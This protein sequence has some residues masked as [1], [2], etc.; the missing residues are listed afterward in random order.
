MNPTLKAVLRAVVTQR[1][2]DFVAFK[3]NYGKKV[4]GSTTLGQLLNG[5]EGIPTSLTFLLQSQWLSE[6]GLIVKVP[7]VADGAEMIDAESNVSQLVSQEIERRAIKIERILQQSTTSSSS[8]WEYSP[9]IRS[10]PL[11]Q[12]CYFRFMA[13]QPQS[14]FFTQRTI[15][16]KTEFWEPIAEDVFN[17]LASVV[18]WRRL[19]KPGEA[20][21]MS[22]I[23]ERANNIAIDDPHV[24]CLRLVS[25]THS[26]PYLAS[27]A[28][29]NLLSSTLR[30]GPLARAT[31]SKTGPDNT[32]AD[33]L[34]FDELLALL[35]IGLGH[36]WW[37]RV[38]MIPL[39]NPKSM[40]L[41][42]LQQEFIH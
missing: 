33:A 30:A 9:A 22:S 1:R 16:K 10:L 2:Q 38:V 41:T 26:D 14:Q 20:L 17:I 40:D 3:Q 15:V 18:A 11:T 25:S 35:S 39:A 12:Q 29:C 13:Q 19:V 21:P 23:I 42:S 4:F 7:V 31:T 6:K 34:F 36:V 5:S 32:D 8:S 27:A 37:D 28:L 24:H